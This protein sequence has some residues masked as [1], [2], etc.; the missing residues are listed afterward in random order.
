MEIVKARKQGNRTI[1]LVPKVPDIFENVE[2]NEY[3]DADTDNLVKDVQLR[4]S[5]LS[6]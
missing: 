6:D 2:P 5:E 1:I 3:F 4:G